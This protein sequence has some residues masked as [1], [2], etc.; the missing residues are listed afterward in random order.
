[1]ALVSL[2]FSI[3]SIFQSLDPGIPP[4]EASNLAAAYTSHGWGVFVDL[5][6]VAEH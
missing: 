4:P 1:M 3:K 2:T 5:P 6:S